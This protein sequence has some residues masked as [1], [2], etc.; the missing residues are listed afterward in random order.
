MKPLKDVFKKATLATVFLLPVFAVTFQPQATNAQSAEEAKAMVAKLNEMLNKGNLDLVDEI[1]SADLVRHEVSNEETIGS[2]AIRDWVTGA[3]TIC[4]DLSFITKEVIPKD[5]GFVW[6]WMAT[7]TNTGPIDELPPTNKKLE[8][9]GV[10]VCRV[11]NGKI[12][13][14][15]DYWNDGLVWKQLG[16][17]FTPPEAVSKK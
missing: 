5:D 13:E 7:G 15:W 6:R 1:Y 11:D 12:V 10:F 4:P 2:D 3:R 14:E 17:T 16:Y 9:P 8:I